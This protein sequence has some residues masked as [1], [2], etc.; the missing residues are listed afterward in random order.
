MITATDVIS[1]RVINVAIVAVFVP[2]HHEDVTHR[3][4]D[5]TDL[6]ELGQDVQHGHGGERVDGVLFTAV[7]RICCMQDDL[8]QAVKE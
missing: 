4:T 7:T 2:T 1:T 6:R 5:N 8:K 3:D